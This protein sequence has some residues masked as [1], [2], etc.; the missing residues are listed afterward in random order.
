MIW[1]AVYELMSIKSWFCVV[2][3]EVEVDSHSF[4]PICLHLLA[5]VRLQLVRDDVAEGVVADGRPRVHLLHEF[6][7]TAAQLVV[8][9]VGMQAVGVGA[10]SVV[11][12]R[13]VGLLVLQTV[14]LVLEGIGAVPFGGVSNA[15][16]LVE[17]VHRAIQLLRPVDAA[18][19]QALARH[20][21]GVVE[22]L[23]LLGEHISLFLLMRRVEILLMEF[24]IP[25]V[26]LLLDDLLVLAPELLL[27]LG[28]FKP[29][30]HLILH[31]WVVV[32]P[33]E[34]EVTLH[35]VQG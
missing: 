21:F 31:R 27:L 30:A 4:V 23:E 25:T 16:R 17:L 11:V 24:V 13:V 26:Q 28:Q 8:R 6:G 2:I 3:K 33:V 22:I 9:L 14:V 15:Q 19:L 34:V 12:L 18:V 29:L 35:V 20:Y 32:L 7:R 10:E 1:S 5:Q